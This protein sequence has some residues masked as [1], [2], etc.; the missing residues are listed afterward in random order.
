MADLD[1]QALSD[2]CEWRD[3]YG[4]PIVRN[5]LRI[6]TDFKGEEHNRTIQA[7]NQAHK[8]LR[9]AT[10]R[11]ASYTDR[12]RF[13][14]RWLLPSSWEKEAASSI[15][16]EASKSVREEIDFLAELEVFL[17]RRLH[18]LENAF[19]RCCVHG[20]SFV[21]EPPM[22]RTIQNPFEFFHQPR[23]FLRRWSPESQVHL[24]Q[25]YGFLAGGWRALKPA[26]SL[27][28]L[29][30]RGGLICRDLKNHCE[31]TRFATSWISMIDDP[32]WMLKDTEEKYPLDS[33]KSR[34]VRI[35][36]ISVAR[37][38]RL[39]VLFNRSNELVQQAGG[40]KWRQADNSSSHKSIIK[41]A[42]ESHYLAYGWIP[43]QCVLATWTVEEYRCLCLKAGIKTGKSS[44]S[45]LGQ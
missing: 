2:H 16:E 40:R 28:E 18:D 44:S 19:I 17:C 5:T 35:S 22:P 7:W 43:F 4:V 8:M 12:I 26:S 13:I 20:V 39:N 30:E 14:E 31:G 36:A 34:E 42:W 24:D 6:E 25:T 32:V 38:N 3:P 45:F 27:E 33:S 23:I 1:K 37:L 21:K 9:Q 15:A 29:G 10:S 11:V 41:F